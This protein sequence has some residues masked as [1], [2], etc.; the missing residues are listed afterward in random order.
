MA[1]SAN[2]DPIGF[3]E[4]PRRDLQPSVNLTAVFRVGTRGWYWLV[5]GSVL[6]GVAFGFYSSQSPRMYRSEVL[7]TVVE[8]AA[9]GAGGGASGVERLG[10]VASIVGLSLGGTQARR[11]EYIALLS[12]RRLI[13][14]FIASKDLL[15]VL[16]AGSWDAANGAWNSSGSNRE[17]PTINSAIAY[18]SNKVLFVVEDRKTGLVRISIE[19][20]DPEL[21]ATWAN[22]LVSLVNADVRKTTIADAK[23]TLEFLNTEVQRTSEIQIRDGIYRLIEG[24]L[25]RIAL[26]NVQQEYALKILDPARAP[27]PQQFVRPR[28]LLAAIAG[29]VLGGGF[30]L[31]VLLWRSRREWLA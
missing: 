14:E 2:D 13:A 24:S 12:S 10:A 31:L 25:S 18:F 4:S 21:A 6:F 20:S 3:S 27:D 29:A 23:S 26:A 9:S 7:V 11:S 15:P 1:M 5:I 30:G 22:D 17:P 19:W 16:Y 28:P 8:D